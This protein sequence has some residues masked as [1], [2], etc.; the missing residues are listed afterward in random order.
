VAGA[1]VLLKVDLIAQYGTFL[2][3]NGN[4]SWIDAAAY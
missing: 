1:A 4:P 3:E 2:C